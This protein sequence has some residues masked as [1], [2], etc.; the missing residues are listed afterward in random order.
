MDGESNHTYLLLIATNNY[1]PESIQRSTSF[2][3]N[4]TPLGIYGRYLYP[5]LETT[6]QY[7][8]IK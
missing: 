7:H 8:R 3:Y 5:Y 6:E 2:V 4:V 1:T